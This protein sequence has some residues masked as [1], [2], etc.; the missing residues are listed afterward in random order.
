MNMPRVVIPSDTK[1]LLLYEEHA[2]TESCAKAP[3]ELTFKDSSQSDKT[4]MVM[5]EDIEAA[6]LSL[7]NLSNLTEAQ[8][9][10]L[11]AIAERR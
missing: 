1:L 7:Q 9:N 6:G 5:P 3:H 8:F 2:I 4:I 10:N 11:V